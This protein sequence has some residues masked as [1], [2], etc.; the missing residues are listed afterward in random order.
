[1]AS[2]DVD[3]SNV[4][5]P[6]SAK[7]PMQNLVSMGIYVVNKAVLPWCRATGSLMDLII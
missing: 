7:N 3:A 1:M 2:C 6:A 4:S 5:P